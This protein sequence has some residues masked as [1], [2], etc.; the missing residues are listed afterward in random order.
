MLN[1]RTVMTTGVYSLAAAA[2]DLPAEA[3]TRTRAWITG[4]SAE[5]MATAG[6]DSRRARGLLHRAEADLERA[7]FRPE[8]EW[9]GNYR[10]PTTSGSTRPLGL[11]VG[12]RVAAPALVP[13]LRPSQLLPWCQMTG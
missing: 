6:D 5:A 4:M 11:V 8:H 9:I 13:S 2:A 1:R 3:P 7:E 10:R 12:E